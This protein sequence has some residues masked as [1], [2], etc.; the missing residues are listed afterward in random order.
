MRLVSSLVLALL[1]SGPAWA[2]TTPERVDPANVGLTM[3]FDDTWT[4][5]GIVGVRAHRAT[6]ATLSTVMVQRY[7][8]ETPIE[9]RVTVWSETTESGFASAGLTG[10]EA[11]DV[12][13]EDGVRVRR[14]A[15]FGGLPTTNTDGW[16][17]LYGVFAADWFATITI[18]A[19]TTGDDGLDAFDGPAQTAMLDRESRWQ[20]AFAFSLEIPD[21]VVPRLRSAGV[22]TFGRDD[23]GD[24]FDEIEL[25][26]IDPGPPEDD[27][28]EATAESEGLI[29]SLSMHQP[30]GTIETWDMQL[31]GLDAAGSRVDA[32]DTQLNRAVQ[33]RAWSIANDAQRAWITL[34]CVPEACAEFAPQLATSVEAFR[35]TPVP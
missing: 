35:W 11:D 1:I 17:V 14:V 13:R 15:G 10:V 9:E 5:T 31:P 6:S 28:H 3:A 34:V 19:P 20:D 27:L 4:P 30:T 24:G 22:V 32:L 26:I 7:E 16:T 25:L 8:Q 2:Q 33:L 23:D 18:H 29:G 12:A 21:A